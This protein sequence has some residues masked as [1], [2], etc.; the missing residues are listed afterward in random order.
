MHK[1]VVGSPVLPTLPKQ[2]SSIIPG[3]AGFRRS[4]G[5]AS[6]FSINSKRQI[7]HQPR[8]GWKDKAA[9]RKLQ[10]PN[11]GPQLSRVPKDEKNRQRNG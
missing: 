7:R 6:S 9:P 3:R 11:T 10:R 5:L 8:P 2:L 1:A 4:L